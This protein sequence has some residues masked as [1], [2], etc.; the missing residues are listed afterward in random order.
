MIIRVAAPP[1]LRPRPL[2]FLFHKIRFV[3]KI[4]RRRSIRIIPRRFSGS[5]RTD[6]NSRLRISSGRKGRCSSGRDEARSRIIVSRNWDAA[7]A[8]SMISGWDFRPAHC[9][10]SQNQCRSRHRVFGLEVPAQ[11]RISVSFSIMSLIM[12]SSN[13][14]S[15]Y[16]TPLVDQTIIET[17]KEFLYREYPDFELRKL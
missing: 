13:S 3:F 11:E 10:R 7:W 15:Y 17:S 6:S 8:S 12:A 9:R 5:S 2:T 4:V 16:V 1:P 14:V